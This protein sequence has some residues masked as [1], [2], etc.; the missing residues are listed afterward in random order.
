VATSK[1][2]EIWVCNKCR[3]GLNFVET[4]E[5][6]GQYTSHGW[7]HARPVETEHSPE[8]IRLADIPGGEIRTVCDV[9]SE[10]DP[11]NLWFTSGNGGYVDLPGHGR[12]QVR[13]R[14]NAWLVCDDCEELIVEDR[15]RDLLRRC[16]A[17][18]K[19]KYP[20]GRLDT[21]QRALIAD[22]VRVFMETRLGASERRAF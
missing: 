8:P 17:A 13:D 19:V 15:L 1:T 5:P 2:P 16:Y 21:E 10:P 12:L 3:V 20:E 6:D 14:D 11:R 9:C 4:R 18:L 22:R 7:I